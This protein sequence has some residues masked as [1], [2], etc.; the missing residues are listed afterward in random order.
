MTQGYLQ[1]DVLTAAI[2]DGTTSPWVDVR[3]YTHIV[4][5]I[6]GLGTTSG[7]V[8]TIEE[9]FPTKENVWAATP[10]VIST[11]NASDVSGGVQ[12]AVHLTVGAYAFVRARVSTAISGGGSITARLV[13]A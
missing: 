12:K 7:G 9:G 10:S 13:A 4:F 5:Y 1:A 11:V 8:I 3:S 2:N 6:S